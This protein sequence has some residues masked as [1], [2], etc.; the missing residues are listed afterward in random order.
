MWFSIFYRILA[1]LLLL[2]SSLFVADEAWPCSVCYAA[3]SSSLIAYYGT[4]LL[5]TILPLSLVT[6]LIWWLNRR[7]SPRS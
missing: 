1:P 6:G 2:V 7:A 5:L 3:Q 4:T